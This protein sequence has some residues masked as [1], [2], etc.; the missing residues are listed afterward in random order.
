MAKLSAF[1]SFAIWAL[2]S[3]V[4]LQVLTAIGEGKQVEALAV[5]VLAVWPLWFVWRFLKVLWRACSIVSMAVT[6]KHQRMRDQR[7]NH[8]FNEGY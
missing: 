8:Y 2:T 6:T 1:Q 4:G 7:N 3:T 5:T